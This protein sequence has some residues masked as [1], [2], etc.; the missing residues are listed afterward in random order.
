M[1]RYTFYGTQSF[2]I[3]HLNPEFENFKLAHCIY[4]Q[5]ENKSDLKPDRCGLCLFVLFCF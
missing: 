4:R 3:F 2:M 5:I 1:Y